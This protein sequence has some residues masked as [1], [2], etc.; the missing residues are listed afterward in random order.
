MS[1]ISDPVA[2]MR[3]VEVDT[4]SE[5]DQA[6]RRVSLNP[7]DAAAETKF[8][9]WL[10]QAAGGRLY[11]RR[12]K[13]LTDKFPHIAK[14]I[15]PF[16]KEHIIGE[17]VYFDENG[18]MVEPAVTHVAGTKDP[19]EAVR[20]LLAMP[21]HFDY[22]VFDVLAVNGEDITKASTQAR[23]A[24]LEDC[25]CDTGLTLSNPQPLALLE[26]VYEEGVAAGGDGVVIKNL[27]SPYYWRPLGQSEERP[28]GV[29][30]KL[31]PS[32]MDDFVVTGTHRGPKGSLLATLA[33]YHNGRLIEVSDVNNFSAEI[34]EEVLRRISK[35]PF[36][37]EIEYTSRF[38]DPPG[39]LQHPRFAR[40]RDDKDLES[41]LLP[42]KYA[43]DGGTLGVAL[44][45]VKNYWIKPDGEVVTF[46]WNEP[47]EM[48]ARQD[49][50]TSVEDA[51]KHGWIRGYELRSR[52]GLELFD[53]Q[54]QSTLSNVAN[55]LD[56]YLAERGSFN[57]V[58]DF[59][60]PRKGWLQVSSDALE[61]GPILDL[62]YQESLRSKRR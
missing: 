13:D 6:M 51:I 28:S 53:I 59:L 27:L 19:K 36:I 55:F 56:Q 50:F 25:F 62:I 12:G 61:G 45:D 48:F 4:I 37:M 29:W 32:F 44:Q 46:S 11:S 58:I 14:L 43:P 31:K 23:R 38:P 52:I 34:E 41:A 17:L 20:K 1:L 42:E 30:W 24:V 60:E 8:N 33:Q 22:V 40:F 9:G 18:Q 49:G 57:A 47:H 54:N 39:S 21:G 2:L 15:A 5:L 26:K 10:V 7:Q 35:G 16:K 3:L